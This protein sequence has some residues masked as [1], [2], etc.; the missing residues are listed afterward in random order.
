VFFRIIYILSLKLDGI[1]IKTIKKHVKN[2]NTMLI[3]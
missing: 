1:M 3:L 2:I